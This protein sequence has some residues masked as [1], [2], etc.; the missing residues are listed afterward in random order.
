MWTYLGVISLHV[1]VFLDLSLPPYCISFST[2]L[3]LLRACLSPFSL[4]SLG[5]LGHPYGS[6]KV[7]Y[8]FALY[9]SECHFICILL[10]KQSSLGSLDHPGLEGR[11]LVLLVRTM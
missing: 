3:S 1:I 5:V 6:C 2:W 10:I 9:V 4:T 11:K 7:F 8:D